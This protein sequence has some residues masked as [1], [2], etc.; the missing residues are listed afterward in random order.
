[1]ALR[2]FRSRAAIDRISYSRGPLCATK[3]RSTGRPGDKT[4][5]VPDPPTMIQ[6]AETHILRRPNRTG[7]QQK[8]PPF[9][10]DGRWN[11]SARIG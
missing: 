2:E 11:A 3:S 1:M 6:K 7:N 8:N 10:D 5:P 9:A 4:L